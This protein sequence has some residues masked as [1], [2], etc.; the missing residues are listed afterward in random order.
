[1]DWSLL[2]ESDRILIVSEAGM[3]KSHECRSE[4]QRRWENGEPSFFIELSTLAP[5]TFEKSLL[6]EELYRFEDWKRAQSERATFFLDS[7]DELKLTQTSFA[8]ALRAFSQSLGNNLDR[9]CVVI[10]TRPI[11]VDQEIIRKWLPIPERNEPIA[12][13][14]LF[15]KIATRTLHSVDQDSKPNKWRSVALAPLNEKQMRLL[16]AQYG[17]PDAT[18]LLK[19]I[20]A[21]NAQ[22]FSKRP[23][24]FIELCNDW[25]VY[26]YIRSHRDQVD[27]SIDFKLKPRTTRGE[28]VPLEAAKA[29]EGASRLALAA[30]LARKINLWHG[31][32]NDDRSDGA[33]DPSLIL[34]DWREDE[35]RT[36]L[37]RPLF[38]FANYGRVR[39]HHRSVIEFLAAE[40]LIEL[41]RK[42]LPDRKLAELAFATGPEGERLI[43]PTM[44]PVL[45]WLARD[46][47]YVRDELLRH[48]PSVLLHHGDPESLDLPLRHQ[49][50]ERYVETYGQGG[51][52][53][54][55]VPDL[56][57]QRFASK[58]FSDQIDR[59]WRSGIQNPE[60][61]G[62]LM[63]LIGAARI[64]SNA[65]IAYEAAVDTFGD[66]RDRYNALDALAKIN[67]ARLPHLLDKISESDSEW[68]LHVAQIAVVQLFPK[69]MSAQQFLGILM[70]LKSTKRRSGGISGQLPSIIEGA[71]LPAVDLIEVRQGLQT[72]IFENISWHVNLHKITSPRKDLISALLT[73]CVLELRLKQPG[74]DIH[75]A[76]AIGILLAKDDHYSRDELRE[77]R[78]QL[79]AAHETIREDVFWEIDRIVCAYHP[80]SDRSLISRIYTLQ[81]QRVYRTDTQKD[82][83]WMLRTA[84]DASVELEKRQ[85][86][87]EFTIQIAECDAD[88]YTHLDKLE[89]ASADT[90]QLCVRVERFRKELS[91][92]RPLPAWQ[93]KEAERQEKNRRKQ[94]TMRETWTRFYRDIKG[95]P[96][97]A[98]S[99]ANTE[100][101]VWRFWNVMDGSGEGEFRRGW[102]RGFVERMFD[103]EIADRFREA[104]AGSWR[105][106]RPT[107]KYERT[108]EEKNTYLK[109][110]LQGLVG[111]YAEAED[112]MWATKLNL[113]EAEIA[114]R[115][116]LVDSRIPPWVESLIEVHPDVVDEIIGRELSDDLRSGPSY[117]MLLSGIQE[118]GTKISSFFFPRVYSWLRDAIADGSEKQ[119][120]ELLKRVIQYVLEFGSHEQSEFIQ[121][122]AT[123]ILASW[124]E[125]EELYLWLPVL[126]RL[127]MQAFVEVL[128]RLG[129]SIEPTKYSEMVKILGHLFGHHASLGLTDLSTQPAN[130]LRVLKIANRHVRSEDDEAHDGAPSRGGRGD[131]EYAR[132]ML[133]NALLDAKGPEAWRL[134]LQLADQPDVTRYRNRVIAIARE[135]MATDLDTFVLTEK[136]VFQFERDFEFAPKSRREMADLLAARLDD[137]DDLLRRDE[138]PRELWSKN[139][140]EKVLRRA[141]TSE[142]K[143]MSHDGYI[144][145]QEAVTGDE[146]ETDIRLISRSGLVEASIELKVGENGYSV[147]DLRSALKEQLVGKYLLPENRR[148]GALVISWNGKKTWEDPDT[149]ATVEFDELISRL[150]SEAKVL[151]ASLGN[152]AFL[153]VRG[154]YLGP[155]KFNLS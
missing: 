63:A 78:Y 148:V 7:V 23:L 54:Q 96:D 61:R 73:A 57:V 126:G 113:E 38:G 60:V 152:D 151:Q 100:R 30:L 10:T 67:D 110:W 64:E 107:V 16:A 62:T 85:V 79:E 145:V 69:Y 74:A 46:N 134:K 71:N 51:W 101:T 82:L 4:Q 52:R 127:N 9:A 47:S 43:K 72:L 122:K 142:L 45:A 27:H 97:V 90:P 99:K 6:E 24:D 115:Y 125:K 28:I 33:L 26:G 81:E 129:T 137:I 144:S 141:L 3:G 150:D 13:E 11:P 136:E 68:P 40:R 36:L 132:S 48:D 21:R 15:V 49:A 8:S 1:M 154:L 70:R 130:V 108:E 135:K 32:E 120:R 83:D 12:Q 89:G 93:V 59:L 41:R 131:A 117:S 84:A 19:A 109:G 44:V 2:L 17:I 116:A 31:A 56:Q 139:T 37:E 75:Q 34:P 147:K 91:T 105:S 65:D 149:G 18:E 133:L 39:F 98:F 94:E 95:N 14:E 66:G 103:K 88:P 92:P 123:S 50:L 106:F 58:D 143:H 112:P 128:E 35:I 118:A 25:R 111:V 55:P 138:S 53:G 5:G 155:H 119:N 124:E 146:K 121:V 77:L 29:R 86:A 102:N 153:S 76:I 42:G 114:C 22:E 20:S 104:F 140:E 87:I 80:K